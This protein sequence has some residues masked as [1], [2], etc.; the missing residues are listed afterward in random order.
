MRI[1]TSIIYD[2]N[3]STIGRQQVDLVHTQQQLSTGSRVV[4]PSDDPVASARALEVSQSVAHLAV[5][6]EN[7]GTAMDTLKS[8]DSQL[9]SMSDVLDYIRERVVQAGDGTLSQ[10]DRD[11]LATDIRTQFDSLLNLANTKDSSGD[12]LFSGYKGD[13]QAF[14]GNLSG[15]TYQGDQGVRTLLVSNTRQVP[16]SVNGN[17]LL[18]NISSINGTFTSSANSAAAVISDGTVSGPVAYSG[19]HYGIKFTSATTY[20]VFDTEA[21]PSMVG[22]PLGSG[23]YVSGQTISLPDPSD[24]TTTEIQVS[25][26]GSPAAGDTFAITPGSSSDVFSTIKQLVIGLESTTGTGYSQMISDTLGRLDNAMENITRLRAQGGSRQ[27]EV[28]ALQNI[29]GDTKIQYADR[30][31]RLVGLDYASAI[32]DFQQQQTYLEAAR[33]TFAKISG[34]SLFNFIS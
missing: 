6:T 13:A 17:E 31:D 9:G 8:L 30:L 14:S 4:N 27:V 21:D 25:I 29:G 5:Q 2:T 28:E 22:T 1:S 3:V 33:N 15:V 7:Q 26:A 11:S 24:A 12:Y 34:L 20:D 32:S 18:M 10:T 23:T 16:V 19:S